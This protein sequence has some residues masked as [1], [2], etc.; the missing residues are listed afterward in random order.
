M[1]NYTNNFEP[2]TG[3]VYTGRNLKQSHLRP[4][5][6]QTNLDMLTF[7]LNSEAWEYQT[8]EIILRFKDEQYVSFV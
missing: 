5:Q 7:K 6:Q 8:T 1:H 4:Q 3:Y 2:G